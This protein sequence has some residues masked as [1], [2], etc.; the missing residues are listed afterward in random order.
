MDGGAEVEADQ[1]PT[2][3]CDDGNACTEDTCMRDG[4]CQNTLLLED[5]GCA[6]ELTI[7][8][9][10]NGSTYTVDGAGAGPGELVVQGTA[11]S[12]VAI[13]GLTL[14]GAD[15]TL[16]G[17]D[18]F[19]E[20]T[21]SPA[22]GLNVA[23]AETLDDLGGS[24]RAM[25]STLVSEAFYQVSAGP[26]PE[27][28]VPEGMVVRLGPL[29]WDDD[30]ATLAQGAF[31]GLALNVATLAASLGTCNHNINVMDTEYHVGSVLLVPVDGGFE[32]KVELWLRATVDIEAGLGFGCV[33]AEGRVE[34]PSGTVNL[35]LAASLVD[36]EVE[37]E[38]VQVD[39]ALGQ[40]A[41]VDDAFI[42]W[43]TTAKLAWGDILPGPLGV[44][45]ES[46]V[47]VEFGTAAQALVVQVLESTTHEETTMTLPAWAP[48]SAGT[49]VDIVAHPQWLTIDPEGALA[50]LAVSVTNTD[51]A[52]LPTPLG[53]LARAGCLEGAEPPAEVPSDMPV[54]TAVHDDV[55]NALRFASWR[56]GQLI[57]AVPSELT[58]SLELPGLTLVEISLAP[59]LPPVLTSCGSEGT[60]LLQ[61]GALGVTVEAL[62]GEEP[63][64]LELELSV[65]AAATSQVAVGS[66]SGQLGLSLFVDKS[67]PLT[68]LHVVVLSPSELPV[69]FESLEAMLGELLVDLLDGVG[70]SATMLFPLP[71]VEVEGTSLFVTP[72]LLTRQD[73]YFHLS[74]AVE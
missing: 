70:S 12:G 64:T 53:A 48:G 13:A 10:A 58:A 3:E 26:G 18:G 14:N 44:A 8:T 43:T 57:G 66:P 45:L 15:I 16:P 47:E 41:L 21:L 34:F 38:V 67:V 65:S 61:L 42:K 33:P 29:F 24:D 56:G 59:Q 35:G 32:L 31:D 54:A 4:S 36:G 72:T 71:Q 9:P 28:E 17:A 25:T 49:S 46:A 60:G 73:G 23:L 30:V 50:G 51:E 63:I 20:A 22:H 5:P 62:M 40:G 39:A 69:A 6:T 74:G 52:A 37:V 11:T 27:A 55:L 19:W 2:C 7:T 68:D 1:G